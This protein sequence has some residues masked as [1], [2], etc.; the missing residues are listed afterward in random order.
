MGCVSNRSISCSSLSDKHITE[1][2][3][4]SV[5]AAEEMQHFD[6]FD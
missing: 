2:T 6:L 1:Y 4:P 3:V 5:G